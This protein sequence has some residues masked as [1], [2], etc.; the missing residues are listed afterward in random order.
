MDELVIRFPASAL[1]GDDTRAH[2]FE[3]R[4]NEC[5]PLAFRVAY[6]VLQHRQDAED[7][8]QEAL[9][10]AFR[11]LGRLRNRERLRSWL[12]RITWRLALDRRRGDTR[13]LARERAA[14]EATDASRGRDAGRDGEQLWSALE[15]IPE[16]LRLVLVLAAIFGYEVREVARALGLP[17]GTVRSRLFLARK[18]LAEALQWPAK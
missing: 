17:E 3:E 14:Y 16:R 9:L 1:T 2:E 10:K 13:R 4:L 6:S 8:A 18:A 11:G 7:V 12:V 5:A 15:A